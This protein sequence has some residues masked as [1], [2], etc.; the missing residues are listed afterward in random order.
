[1]KFINQN[2]AIIVSLILAYTFVNTT[3]EH[4][5]GVIHSLF[6]VSPDW[7]ATKY[8]FPVIIVAFLIFPIIRW[9]KKKIEA[10]LKASPVD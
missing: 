6:G 2:I 5:P 9:L 1:M 4:W 3:G 7:S 10:S 8:R